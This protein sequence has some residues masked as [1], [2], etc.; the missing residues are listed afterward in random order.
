MDTERLILRA[1]LFVLAF[2]GHLIGDYLLQSK[3]MAM[4]KSQPGW[5]GVLACTI[6]VALYTVAVCAMVQTTDAL[7]WLAVAVPHWIIDRWSLGG[8]WLKVIR[9]R[10]LEEA[11]LSAEPHRPFHIA[12][13]AVVYT[14]AD[15]TIHLLCLW[16][17]IRF[18]LI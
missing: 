1:A 4:T 8:W 14:A 16:A 13:F 3:W 15:N 2:L 10:T 17:A 11:H 9:G 18:L 12:F 7:V 6:H 5:R